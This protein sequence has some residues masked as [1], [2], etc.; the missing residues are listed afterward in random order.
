MVTVADHFTLRTKKSQFD[1]DP[2]P[3]F[4]DKSDLDPKKIISDPQHWLLGTL[5][6]SSVAAAAAPLLSSLATQ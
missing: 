2:D 4:P 5:H 3:K 1:L 6:S